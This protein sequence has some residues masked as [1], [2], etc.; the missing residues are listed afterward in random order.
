METNVKKIPHQQ[1]Y[2][3]HNETFSK[4]IIIGSFHE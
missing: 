2:N 1:G 3:Y 4:D